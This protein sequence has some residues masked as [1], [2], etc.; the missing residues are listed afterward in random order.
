MMPDYN[1]RALWLRGVARHLKDRAL[2]AHLNNH[3]DR[4]ILR[5]RHLRFPAYIEKMPAGLAE[6]A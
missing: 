5:A 6:T 1:K 4:M 2:A 3:A